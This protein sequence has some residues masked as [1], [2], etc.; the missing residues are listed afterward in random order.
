MSKQQDGKIGR[1]E[2]EIARGMLE[3][4]RKKTRP[5][6]HD[7]Y[8]VFCAGLYR[9]NTG[10]AWRKLPPGSPPWRTVHGYFMQWTTERDGGTL[11]QCA[12][13]ALGIQLAKSRL[14]Q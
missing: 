3:A 5:R 2:F 11:L 8:D 1:E 4:A 9:L 6:K 10:A 14:T 13:D 7:L 12:L